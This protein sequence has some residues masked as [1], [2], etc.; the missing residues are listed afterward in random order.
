MRSAGGWSSLKAMR[1][2]ESRMKGDERIL[3]QGN[4]V[5]SVLKPAQE[6]LDRKFRIAALVYDFD[7]LVD[8]VLGLFDHTTRSY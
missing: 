4:F 5:E 6:N 8:Q 3:D 7:W 1:K 2:C